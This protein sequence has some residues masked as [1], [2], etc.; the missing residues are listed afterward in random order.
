M[1]IK[2]N[3]GRKTKAINSELVC[4]RGIIH[5]PLHFGRDSRAG[6][7]VEKPWNEKQERL[8]VCPCG[9]LLAQK[10]RTP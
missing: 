8:Q 3:Q 10:G 7:E 1:E 5:Y 9:R 4:S 2:D 6:R